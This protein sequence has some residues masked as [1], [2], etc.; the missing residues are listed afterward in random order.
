M[1]GRR[2]RPSLIRS[3]LRGPATMVTSRGVA[4]PKLHIALGGRLPITLA[5][6]S[7][8]PHVRCGR[9]QPPAG[10]PGPLRAQR[11]PLDG[12]F[13]L[14]SGHGDAQAPA[15]TATFAFVPFF[16]PVAVS[17]RRSRCRPPWQTAVVPL[18]RCACAPR[19]RVFARRDGFTFLRQG[20]R[21]ES[22]LR[23]GH[24]CTCHS[25]AV[26]GRIET[27]WLACDPDTP[28]AARPCGR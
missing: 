23:L 24:D 17:R 15:V 12:T 19:R 22:M 1:L 4:L 2:R 13:I 6:R 28:V 16:M 11:V 26:A 7:V 9:R 20:R 3:S 8:R 18:R 21:T 14:P 5:V 10:E 27:V 25:R